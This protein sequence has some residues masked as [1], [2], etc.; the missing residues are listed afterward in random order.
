L[1]VKLANDDSCGF[2]QQLQG[3]L[4]FGAKQNAT[5]GSMQNKHQHM[6][7]C[8]ISSCEEDDMKS[9]KLTFL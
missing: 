3:N 9:T 8:A 6:V 2:L 4:V 5:C 7:L 1:A